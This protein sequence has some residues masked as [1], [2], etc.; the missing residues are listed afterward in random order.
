MLATHLRFYGHRD[1]RNVSKRGLRKSTATSDAG[2]AGSARAPRCSRRERVTPVNGGGSGPPRPG[3][4][5]RPPAS[6]ITATRAGALRNGARPGKGRAT[7]PKSRPTPPRESSSHEEV[8]YPGGMSWRVPR[9]P[10]AGR[11]Q[12]TS[13]V[14]DAKSARDYL[15]ERVGEP[16]GQILV[17]A[18]AVA[19]KPRVPLPQLR[20]MVTHLRAAEAALRTLKG[21]RLCLWPAHSTYGPLIAGLDELASEIERATTH[22]LAFDFDPLFESDG[23]LLYAFVAMK[24]S[25]LVEH[26]LPSVTLLMAGAVAGGL[27]PATNDRDSRHEQW[28]KR[29]R[30]ALPLFKDWASDFGS[31]LTFL[32]R[33]GGLEKSRLAPIREL[34]DLVNAH[35]W[36]S[37]ELNHLDMRDRAR[38][39]RSPR[40]AGKRYLLDGPTTSP[41]G[42]A[43]GSEEAPPVP[44]PPRTT[45]HR[46]HGHTDPARGEGARGARSRRRRTTPP[47]A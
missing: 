46:G 19:R 42:R 6:P 36:T 39:A 31:E 18:A 9:P 28:R 10:V 21:S 4:P 30:V 35:R 26:E 17:S 2:T 3:R 15:R 41:G 11:A 32:R 7:A 22:A 23:R 40:G 45:E 12:A 43:A 1:D 25:A 44:V 29:R 5:R 24:Y 13:P 47:G 27:E 20:D 33:W 38:A 14:G 8:S 16:Y 34:E 37:S